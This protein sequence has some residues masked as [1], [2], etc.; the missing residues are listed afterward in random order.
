MIL[1]R[2]FQSWKIPSIVFTLVV[3]SLVFMFVPPTQSMKNRVLYQAVSE[4]NVTKAS[5]VI[6]EG[7]QTNI[8]LPGGLPLIS[9]AIEYENAELVKLLLSDDLNV[10]ADYSGY[11]MMEHALEKNNKDIVLLLVEHI[12]K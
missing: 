9:L 5:K 6:K 12:K 2:H 8:Q 4:N 10:S 11:V 3:L 7:A 1:V